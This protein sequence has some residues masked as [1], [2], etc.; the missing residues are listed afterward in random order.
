MQLLEQ[1]KKKGSFYTITTQ[2]FYVLT[3][4]NS[5]LVWEKEI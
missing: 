1:K 2:N 3:T 5:N 4:Q